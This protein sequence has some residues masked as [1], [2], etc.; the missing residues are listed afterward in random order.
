MRVLIL[1]A[2]GSIGRHLVPQAL[3]AGHEVTV[4]VR[5]KFDP[6]P[7]VRVIEGDALDP[8]KLHEA[9]AGQQAVVYSLGFSQFNTLT[10]FFSDSTR[11]LIEAMRHHGVRRF[12]AITGVGAGDSKG[13]GGFFY[14]Q[15][16]YRFFT[17][18]IYEDKNR[19]EALIRA[20][21]L[22]WVIVRPA[23]FTNGPLRD[24]LRAFTQLDG[25]T[26]KSI[27][28]ADAAAFVLEQLASDR[29][30]HQSPLVGY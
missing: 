6:E 13:H 18:R 22:D 4:L 7:G 28:R 11:Y 21:N 19:Q 20:S 25:I 9:V 24:H 26:I 30:L 10:T 27:S 29:F 2:K 8:M 1:G 17:R 12:I 15:I 23:S 5:S 16:I 14:D 3:A